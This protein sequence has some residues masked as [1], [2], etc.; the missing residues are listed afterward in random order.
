MSEIQVACKHVY[1][2]ITKST[3]ES[4]NRKEGTVCQTMTVLEV[5]CS[6]CGELM[7]VEAQRNVPPVIAPRP[8]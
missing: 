1:N 8:S 7:S 3:V 5:M 6:Q 2:V 4:T